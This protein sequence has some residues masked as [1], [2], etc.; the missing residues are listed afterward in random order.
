MGERFLTLL[1]ASSAPEEVEVDH[2]FVVE[3]ERQ[4]VV[5]TKNNHGQRFFYVREER[6]LTPIAVT[7]G[8]EP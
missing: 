1:P 2:W 6:H 4:A 7:F 5:F 8:D 3:G